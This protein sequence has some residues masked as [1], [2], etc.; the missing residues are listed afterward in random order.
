MPEA[1]W[2]PLDG[3]LATRFSKSAWVYLS[4]T[5]SGHWFS[6]LARLIWKFICREPVDTLGHK[7]AAQKV[8]HPLLGDASSV[9][10]IGCIVGYQSDN[11]VG[12]DIH[13]SD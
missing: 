13:G 2:A 7:S 4:Y 5:A 9:A 12:L 1:V 10:G 3:Q 6:N 8:D 11:S